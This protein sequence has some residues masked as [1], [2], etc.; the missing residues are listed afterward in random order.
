MIERV[1]VELLK[2]GK[3][4]PWTCRGLDSQAGGSLIQEKG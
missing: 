4:V 3:V 2:S 1:T